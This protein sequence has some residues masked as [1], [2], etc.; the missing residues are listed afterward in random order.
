MGK[1]R[2]VAGKYIPSLYIEYIIKRTCGKGKK[3]VRVKN[4]RE[5]VF[6]F[7]CI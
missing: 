2:K 1:G 6:P 4:V 3:G 5:R 7:F